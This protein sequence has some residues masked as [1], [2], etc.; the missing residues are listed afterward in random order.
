MTLPIPPALWGFASSEGHEISHFFKA[1]VCLQIVWTYNNSN[2]QRNYK[3]APLAPDCRERE[4]THMRERGSAR[5]NGGKAG[6][7]SVSHSTKRARWL[8]LQLKQRPSYSLAFK[9]PW[10][11]SKGNKHDILPSNHKEK[12]FNVYIFI[13]VWKYWCNSA[14]HLCHWHCP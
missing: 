10:M 6:F 1:V 13:R 14:I 4:V 12:G 3:S 5:E 2:P 7:C 9:I 11:T 8:F